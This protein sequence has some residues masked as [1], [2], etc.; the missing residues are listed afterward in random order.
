MLIEHL[1]CKVIIRSNLRYTNE[2]VSEVAFDSVHR[3]T[4]KDFE[5]L[6]VHRKTNTD[7]DRK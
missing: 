5:M 4:E 6:T 1:E 2:S 7:R 3:S